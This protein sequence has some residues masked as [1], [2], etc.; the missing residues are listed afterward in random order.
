[1]ITKKVNNKVRNIKFFEENFENFEKIISLDPVD[2]FG[3]FL[4]FCDPSVV[5]Q[6]ISQTPESW[7]WPI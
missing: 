6:K 7:T 3:T 1:M 2:R 5:Y 4:T